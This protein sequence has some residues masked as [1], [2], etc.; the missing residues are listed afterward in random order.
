V[1]RFRLGADRPRHGTSE[2]SAILLCYTY[3]LGG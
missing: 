1:A 2:Q 3:L